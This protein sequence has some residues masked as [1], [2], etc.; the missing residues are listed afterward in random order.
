MKNIDKNENLEFLKGINKNPFKTP[1]GYFE[2][3]EKEVLNKLAPPK[4]NIRVV[5]NTRFN[6]MSIAASVTLLICSGYLYMK[7]ESSNRE[8][9]MVKNE[10]VIKNYLLDRID[11]VDYETL[12][13]WNVAE[14]DVELDRAV[15]E[16]LDLDQMEPE[17]LIDL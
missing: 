5:K 14:D 6:L 8:N 10:T 16:E 9:A 11:E 17:S 4:A 13:S 3:L 2:G 7:M 12:Y 1:V 15:I